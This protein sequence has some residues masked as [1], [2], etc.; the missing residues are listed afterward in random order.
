MIV[1]FTPL[2]AD[3]LLEALS[4]DRRDRASIDLLWMAAQ[5]WLEYGGTVN[6]NRFLPLPATGGKL[7][8]AARDLW[9]RKAS[10]LL[11]DTLTET[12]A[13][14][15]H[16]ELTVFV[17]RGAWVSWAELRQPPADASELRKSLFFALKHNDKKVL[18]VR[19]IDRILT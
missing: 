19:Q 11:G 16:R 8:Q 1:N 4:K 5:S 14:T 2:C 15:L 12:R 13:A 17:S 9:L 7:K 6:M 10:R 3:A 18:S